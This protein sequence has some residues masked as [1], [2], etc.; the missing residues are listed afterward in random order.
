MYFEIEVIKA[1][2]FKISSSLQSFQA[3]LDAVTQM[4]AL[5]LNINQSL[6]LKTQY[7]VQTIKKVKASDIASQSLAPFG[8]VSLPEFT[9][10]ISSSDVSQPITL[11]VIFIMTHVKKIKRLIVV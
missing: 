10:L 9:D 6:S 8:K 4:L 7:F 5:R 1:H 3:A 11:S 2:L